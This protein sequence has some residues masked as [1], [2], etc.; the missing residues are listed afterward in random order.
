MLLSKADKSSYKQTRLLLFLIALMLVF[1][2]ISLS[3]QEERVS[4]AELLSRP[5]EFDGKKVKLQGEV[6]QF[7]I[8]SSGG[9]FIQLNDDPYAERSIAEGSKPRGTN[10]AISVFLS[11]DFAKK[12]MYFGSYRYKGDIIEI[13]GKFNI[14]CA[15]HQGETDVHADYLRVIKRG[16]QIKHPLNKKLLYFSIIVFLATASALVYWEYKKRQ[17]EFMRMKK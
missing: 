6:V 4:V 14:S 11:D 7:K 8:K 2:V 3:A 9:Y 1:P 15:E 5:Q 16:Y 12:I 17:P 13:A 10:N